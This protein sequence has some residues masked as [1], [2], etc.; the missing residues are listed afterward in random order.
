V[1]FGFGVSAFCKDGSEAPPLGLGHEGYT[2]NAG[3][4]GLNKHAASTTVKVC[5]RLVARGK[6]QR[7]QRHSTLSNVMEASLVQVARDV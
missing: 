5:K 4:S 7:E 3:K 6:K 2:E 1:I